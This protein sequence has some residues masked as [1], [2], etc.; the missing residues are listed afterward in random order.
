MT[1]IL[2]MDVQL[3]P[4]AFVTTDAGTGFVHI[5]PGHGEDDFNLGQKNKIKF[6]ETVGPDGRL[7]AQ[8]KRLYR[9]VRL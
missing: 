9:F 8:Y 1:D 2:I 5:A 7:F 4:G 6:E 3:Y